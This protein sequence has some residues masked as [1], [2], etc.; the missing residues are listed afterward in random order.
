[1]PLVPVTGGGTRANSQVEGMAGLV[2]ASRCACGA[3]GAASE[4]QRD[5]YDG[6]Y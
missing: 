1:M 4:R 5:Q 2:A 3:R 6:G